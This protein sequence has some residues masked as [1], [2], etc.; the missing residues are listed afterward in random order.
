MLLYLPCRKQN[1]RVHMPKHLVGA[2]ILA[3]A[4][5]H[6]AFDREVMRIADE[7]ARDDSAAHRRVA[8]EILHADI[9][10]DRRFPPPAGAFDR[11]ADFGAALRLQI[12]D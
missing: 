5:V 12:S 4:T 6:R 9:V 7:I 8:R 3:Q 11:A 10:V 1:L 2:R